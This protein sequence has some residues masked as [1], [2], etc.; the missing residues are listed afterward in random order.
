MCSP[1]APR[2]RLALAVLAA[3]RGTSSL[4]CRHFFGTNSHTFTPTDAGIA[5]V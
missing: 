2:A 3:N 5:P 4:F 1:R